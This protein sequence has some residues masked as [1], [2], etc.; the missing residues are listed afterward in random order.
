MNRPTSA[1]GIRLSTD[2]LAQARSCLIIVPA[3]RKNDK[4]KDP[5]AQALARKRW[6]GVGAAERSRLMKNAALQRK[7]NMTPE[8]RS[9]GAKIAGL[10]F[11]AKLSPEERSAEMKRRAAKR[12]KK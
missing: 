10:A 1:L 2:L 6:S 8:Q 4:T 3:V 11:W 5:A 12:K 9:E 7:K